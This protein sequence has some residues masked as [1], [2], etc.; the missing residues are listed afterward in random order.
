M[1]NRLLPFVFFCSLLM[2]PSSCKKFV[3][4]QKEN[5]LEALVTNGTWRITR[6]LDHQT[7]ITSS[8][9]GY[10]FQFKSNGTV[11]GM[12]DEASTTGTWTGD[13]AARTIRSDFP[14]AGA[15]LDKLNYTWTVTDSYKDSVSARTTVDS[16]YNYL[17]LHKN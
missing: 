9:S 7:D 8:F 10:V 4:Q 3:E 6:Y 14:D 11:D 15:P 2:G 5:A 17:E 16:A 1:K 13:V 12:H